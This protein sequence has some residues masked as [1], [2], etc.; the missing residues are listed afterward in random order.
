MGRRRTGSIE[1]VTLLL[2]LALFAIGF[3]AIMNA[4]GAPGDVEQGDWKT[5]FSRMNWTTLGLHTLWFVTGAALAAFVALVDYR[6][7]GRISGFIYLAS[8]AILVVVLAVAEVVYGA[9]SWIDTVFGRTI[10]PSE[11]AKLALIISLAKQLSQRTSATGTLSL[12]D[13]LFILFQDGIPLALIVLQKDL[14]TAA[15]YLV[16]TV[17]MLFLAGA[18]MWMLLV[19]GA[20]AGGAFVAAWMLDLLSDIQKNRILVFLDPSLDPDVA[21]YNLGKAMMAIGSGQLTGKGFFAPGA[22]TQLAYIPVQTKDFIY[23]VIGETFGFLGTATVILLFAALLVRL[24]W[25]SGEV[26]DRFGSLMIA[27]VGAMLGFHAIESIGMCIGAMPI[28]GIPLPF[29]SY[30]GSN[31]WANLLG[32][33]LVLS[34]CLRNK[35]RQD[36]MEERSLYFSDELLD[37]Q[38]MGFGFHASWVYAQE[39]R[40]KKRE[41][42]KKYGG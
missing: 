27:G 20:S 17:V 24:F 25:L 12:R 8:L 22:M 40:K 36:E 21:G 7:Y 26:R 5:I 14:G 18:R 19:T 6:F 15:V 29:I 41:R 4:T 30:G 1:W 23:A 2:V 3:L 32:I 37:Q 11:L 33:G 39:R 28:T 42:R 9:T 34:V 38:Q 13:Y 35:L 16:I 31:M 10:Q